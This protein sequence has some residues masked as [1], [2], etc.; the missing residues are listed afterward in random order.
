MT[1]PGGARLEMNDGRFI[2]QVGLGVFKVP[3]EE[4][5]AVVSEGFAAG[6]RHIDTAAIYQNEAGVGA[7][8]AS[9]GIAREDM[10]ITTKL[11]NTD[12]APEAAWP[13]LHK[14]LDLLGLEYVDLYLIHWPS[15]WRENYLAA[16]KTLI[17]MQ[18]QGLVKSI[19]VSNFDETHLTHIIEKTGVTPVLN[20]IELHPFFAQKRMENVDAGLAILTE[21][22]APLGQGAALENPVLTEIA[23]AQGVSVAQVIIRWHM[24]CGRVVIPKSVTPARIRSNF[25]VFGFELTV[26]EMSR[27]AQLDTDTRIGPDPVTAEF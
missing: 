7:A 27:I 12:Q 3:D 16:W 18:E 21:A 13:A 15:P 24:Q 6:Y 25:D 19:G 22:W 8:I 20:Q 1:H 17:Q 10:F 2:P 5:E 14:S 23:K 26:E 11:W 9:S 4:A